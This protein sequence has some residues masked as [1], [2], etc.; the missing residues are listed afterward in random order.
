M[1]YNCAH[2]YI[3]LCLVP[4]SQGLCIVYWPVSCNLRE[5]QSES[6]LHFLK[7]IEIEISFQDLFSS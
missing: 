6:H 5:V 3:D 1:Y 2:K 4:S 7:Y